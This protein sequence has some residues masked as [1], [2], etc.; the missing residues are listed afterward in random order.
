[1]RI[2]T[3]VGNITM[4]E[5]VAEDDHRTHSF[6]QRG[7]ISLNRKVWEVPGSG[8]KSGCYMMIDK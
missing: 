8:A 5:V 4:S 3:R 6:G 7:W 2:K 1:M